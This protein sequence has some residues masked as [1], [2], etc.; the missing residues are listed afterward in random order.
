MA[1]A[2]VNASPLIFLAKLEQLAALSIFEP[3]FTTPQVVAEIE[4]GLE[5]GYR[6]ALAVRRFIDEGAIA[7]RRAPSLSLPPPRLDPGELS[8]ISLARRTAGATV[9]IDD[10]PAIRAAKHL[11]LRVRSTPFVLLDNLSSGRLGAD[12]FEGLLHE[13]LALEYHIS[14]ALF[15]FLVESARRI[16]GR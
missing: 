7:V 13:L 3:V 6:E 11:G 14:P 8:V 12:R 10:L 4:L 2:V 15:L 5:Q 1:A 16:S 9:V